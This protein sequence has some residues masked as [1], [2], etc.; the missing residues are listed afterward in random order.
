M[1]SVER[2]GEANTINELLG[3]TLQKCLLLV[4]IFN[5]YSIDLELCDQT[6]SSWVNK[7]SQRTSDQ[8]AREI[9]DPHRSRGLRTHCTGMGIHERPS[10]QSN[11]SLSSHSFLYGG[12]AFADCAAQQEYNYT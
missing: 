7:Q 1:L 2:Y 6:S 3:G 9:N 12:M 4:Y 8:L 10:K 11:S 5:Y